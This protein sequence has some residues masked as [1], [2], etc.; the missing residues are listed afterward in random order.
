MTAQVH[1]KDH[2][3]RKSYSDLNAAPGAGA[4]PVC[5]PCSQVLGCVVGQ[6]RVGGYVDLIYQIFNAVGGSEDSMIMV[7]KE[8]MTL[9]S[10]TQEKAI[11]AFCSARGSPMC[12]IAVSACIRTEIPLF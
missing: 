10:M 5:V 9:W 12:I 11:M 4:D 8:L 7:P 1:D 2:E 6:G 3:E